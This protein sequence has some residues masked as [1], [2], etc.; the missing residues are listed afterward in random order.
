MATTRFSSQASPAAASGSRLAT[1]SIGAALAAAQAAL[2]RLNA[3]AAT[4]AIAL[5]F[6]T[7]SPGVGV[8]FP[9]PGLPLS[10]LQVRI[11]SLS[12]LYL[13][14]WPDLSWG[15]ICTHRPVTCKRGTGSVVTAAPK[16]YLL[17][18]C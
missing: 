17:I 6:P 9:T 14:V 4:R 12:S 5:Q 7:P 2:E 18:T 15:V 3:N 1:P 10:R 8:Q 16:T 11:V 13:S